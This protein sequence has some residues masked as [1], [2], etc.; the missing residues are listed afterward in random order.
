MQEV[1]KSQKK[2]RQSTVQE[3][4]GVQSWISPPPLTAPKHYKTSILGAVI[5]SER[6]SLE[7][8]FFPERRV[9]GLLAFAQEGVRKSCKVVES[10]FVENRGKSLKM[11]ENQGKFTMQRGPWCKGVSRDLLL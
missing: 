10:L 1:R 5:V 7:P 2:T 3:I 11:V 8:P 4:N 6:G 9:V